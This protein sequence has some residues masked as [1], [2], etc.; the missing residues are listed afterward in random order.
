MHLSQSLADALRE[1]MRSLEQSTDL[2]PDDPAL[3]TLKRILV[4]KIAA[5][6]NAQEGNEPALAS[7]ADAPTESRPEVGSEHEPQN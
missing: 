6:E 5:L 1:T 7:P 3:L 4:L 2:S